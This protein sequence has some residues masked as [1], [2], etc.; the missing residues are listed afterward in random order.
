MYAT[1]GYYTV[2]NN[3]V[4]IAS[5]CELRKIFASLWRTGVNGI[6]EDGMD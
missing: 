5:F 3:A 1:H 4:V 6:V 2:K